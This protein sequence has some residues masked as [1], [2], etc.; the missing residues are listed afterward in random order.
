LLNQFNQ[1]RNGRSLRTEGFHVLSR[2]N[3][4]DGFPDPFADGR[5]GIRH[6]R[7]DRLAELPFGWLLFMELRPENW[8]REQILQTKKPLRRVAPD[9]SLRGLVPGG[10]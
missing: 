8:E 7:V 10:V 9:R 4:L 3:V 5:F 2:W 6:Q 1:L